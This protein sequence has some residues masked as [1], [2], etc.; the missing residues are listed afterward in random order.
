LAGVVCYYG[1]SMNTFRRL[2]PTDMPALRALRTLYADVFGE[3]MHQASDD[4]LQGLLNDKSIVFFVAQAADAIIG[5]ATAYHLPSLYGQ[6]D[7]LYIYD[8]AI[9]DEHQ[10]QGIGSGL[11]DCIKDY[12]AIHA[13]STVFVQADAVDKHARDFYLKNGGA[14]ED[15]RHYDFTV[16]R[17]P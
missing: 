16:N 7:E 1:H 2:E 5:G 14:E 8:M 10:R 13:V 3:P 9:R 11:L 15:V 12:A 4:Y 6:H 17:A